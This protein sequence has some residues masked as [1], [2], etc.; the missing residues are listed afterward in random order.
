M[1]RE[2]FPEL[3]VELV[4]PEMMFEASAERLHGSAGRL[5]D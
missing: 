5:G 4:C 1:G 3:F 2:G